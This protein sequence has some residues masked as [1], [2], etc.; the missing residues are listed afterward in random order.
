MLRQ[1]I[2]EFLLSQG[3]ISAERLADPSVRMTDLG[4]DSLGVVEMLFEVE[5]RYGI[6]VDDVMQ[7]Q[8][9]TLNEVVANMEQIVRQKHGG[10]IPDMVAV[11]KAPG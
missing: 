6:H 3:N 4:L 11:E 8:N 1:I 9:M 10:N 7:F 5:D 2:H